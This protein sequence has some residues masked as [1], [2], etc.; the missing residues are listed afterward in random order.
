MKLDIRP[1]VHPQ[2]FRRY[3]TK[4]ARERLLVEKIFGEDEINLCLSL[5]DRL[6]FGGAAPASRPLSLDGGEESGLSPFFARREAALICVSGE[7]T[8]SVDSKDYRM[9]KTDGLYVGKGTKELIFRAEKGER[10]RFY[11]ASAPAHEARPALFIPIEKTKRLSAGEAGKASERTIHQYVH[12]EVCG[13]CQLLMGMTEL[14]CGSVWNTMPC[15]TH[16]RRME[17]YFYF[18]IKDGEAVFH[19]H[20]LPQESR[21]LVVQNE[22]AVISPSWSVHSGA[23][24]ANYSFIWAMAGENQDFNDTQGVSPSAMR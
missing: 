11:I 15:H 1:G 17:A 23:G 24:T 5:E 20:G 9:K 16:I 4:T 12:P 18:N 3:D 14:S 6:I 13:S 10:P 7:G 19:L 22:Q 21:H 2:D 8:V